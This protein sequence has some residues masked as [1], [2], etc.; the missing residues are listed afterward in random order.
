MCMQRGSVGRFG[1]GLKPSSSKLK[2]KSIHFSSV[3]FNSVWRPVQ[4]PEQIPPW[5]TLCK[6]LGRWFFQYPLALDSS[7]VWSVLHCRHH[8]KC[9][10]LWHSHPMT[11]ETRQFI[12]PTG[13]KKKL[14]LQLFVVC[15]LLNVPATCQCISGTDLHRQL[16][17]LPHWDR[18]CRSNFL[19]HPVT[20]YWHR[21]DQ[22]QRWPY[23]ARRLAG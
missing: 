7:A 17:V 13:R 5:E 15:W 2:K 12:H 16:Y 9:T 20:V 11:T 6:L 10:S 19:P 8:S 4:L 14:F 23:N 3:Q 18:S 22:S 1:Q 21:A